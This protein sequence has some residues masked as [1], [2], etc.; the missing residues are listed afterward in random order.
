MPWLWLEHNRRCTRVTKLVNYALN[1]V[2]R[3]GFLEDTSGSR[4]HLQLANSVVGS[5]R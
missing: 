1:Y 3:L 2:L 5:C 4:G